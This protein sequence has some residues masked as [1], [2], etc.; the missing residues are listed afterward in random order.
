MIVITLGPMRETPDDP[1]GR[2][3][4]GYKKGMSPLAI[5]D[6]A[7][8]TWHLG[9]K[10]NRERYVLFAFQGHVKLA[11]EISRVDPSPD[12]RSVITGNILEPGHPVY[13]RY[14]NQ[15]SP[16]APQRNPVGYF[17]APEDHTPCLC[18]CGEPTPAGKDFVTGHDQT[19]LHER[20]K[21]I[22]SVKEFMDWFDAMRRPFVA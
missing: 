13:D 2:D 16:I 22:G 14:V 7:R 18:G 4:A 1:L 5:Y 15:A 17:D 20:V 11:V 12:G 3:R 10:A 21:Q 9:A 19:A 6:A 8:G